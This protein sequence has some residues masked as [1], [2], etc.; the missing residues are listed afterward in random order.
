MSKNQTALEVKLE[1]EAVEAGDKL[2]AQAAAAELDKALLTAAK[3]AA[4][5]HI[6]KTMGWI[7]LTNHCKG[8]LNR[9]DVD[10]LELLQKKD[11]AKLEKLFGQA[12]I[13]ADYC[14]VRHA[15]SP[16][17]QKKGKKADG[18]QKKVASVILL[19]AQKRADVATSEFRKAN[20][21]LWNELRDGFKGYKKAYPDI[22]TSVSM[23]I[24]KPLAID[25]DGCGVY[26]RLYYG[27]L[28]K[29]DISVVDQI[30]EI[31][32]ISEV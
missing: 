2:K 12:A 1:R 23:S 6:L 26:M 16:A 7:E 28:K 24:G 18:D 10:D 11:S 30:E 22:K 4:G 20:Q 8:Y 17:T 32:N 15:A 9:L 19:N 14:N 25:E 5:S 3:Q 13:D 31:D 21:A 29:D 27:K